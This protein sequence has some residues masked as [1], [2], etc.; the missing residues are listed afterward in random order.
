[1]TSNTAV[2]SEATERRIDTTLAT[3]FQWVIALYGL[4]WLADAGLEAR[5][6]LFG[7]PAAAHA[8]LVQVF[9]GPAKGA[10][11][12]LHPVLATV[13]NGVQHVGPHAIAVAM[14]AIAAALG[15]ALISRVAL[16][17]ASLAGLAYSLILWLLI[18]GLGFPYGHGQTD[19][20][21]LPAYAISFLFILGARP[22]LD[23]GAAANASEGGWWFAGRILFGLLWVFDANLKFWPGFLFHFVHHFTSK[24][25]GQPHWLAVWLGLIA[26]AAR[27]IGPTPLAVVVGAFELLVG[28]S[29]L[30]GR[31]LRM[32]VPPAMAYCLLVWCTAEAFGGPYTV[33]GSA[34]GG[35]VVGNVIVYLI[36]FLMLAAD[37]FTRRGAAAPAAEAG[38]RGGQPR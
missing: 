20:G 5:S 14:V 8:R 35:H 7:Q 28:F 13:A 12:W 37:L 18:E 22:V 31:G 1:M 19:P 9:A 23:R 26:Q 30:S 29:L 4:I 16:R 17:T 25:A 32:V 24:M 38:G 15:V 2:L 34:V 6:W 11:A 21:V 27:D 36:P 33:R 10:P 3:R